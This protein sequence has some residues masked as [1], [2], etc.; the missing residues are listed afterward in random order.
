MAVEARKEGEISIR[1]TPP[2]NYHVP[3]QYKVVATEADC[4]ILCL[5]I[6]TCVYLEYRTKTEAGQEGF[7]KIADRFD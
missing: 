6:H 3:R 2:I 7:C 4:L 1:N 5:E